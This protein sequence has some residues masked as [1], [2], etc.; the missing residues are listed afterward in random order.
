MVLEAADMQA[1]NRNRDRYPAAT[2]QT[3]GMI[4]DVTQLQFLLSTK[5]KYIFAANTSS[6]EVGYISCS[7][8]TGIPGKLLRCFQ[9]SSDRSRPLL[10]S[11]M[12]S[13]V[14]LT[15]V[16]KAISVRMAIAK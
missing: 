14:S 1:H 3:I 7:K 9:S 10:V 5:A 12:H 11:S 6:I 8:A 13:L 4:E 15:D 2:E 16:E